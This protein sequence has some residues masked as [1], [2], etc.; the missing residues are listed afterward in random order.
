MLKGPVPLS[1]A[2]K[3]DSIPEILYEAPKY[4]GAKTDPIPYIEVPEGKKMPPVLFIMEYSHTGETEVGT[5][6]MPEEIMDQIPH[7]YV[8]FEFLME[9][10][11]DH[12]PKEYV[13]QIYYAL[14]MLSRK[15]AK[16]LGEEALERVLNKVDVLAEEA[17]N[18]QP[19]RIEQAKKMVEDAKIAMENAMLKGKA[20]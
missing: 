3:W 5:N 7:K 6:G 9:R 11:G 18:T 16:K 13:T 15:D 14:G 17:N 4:P 8:D 12:I 19:T 20:N 10:I 2:H 1:L